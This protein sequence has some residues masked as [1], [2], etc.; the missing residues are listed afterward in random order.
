[1]SKADEHKPT[2]DDLPP[3]VRHAVPTPVPAKVTAAPSAGT[4][5]GGGINFLDVDDGKGDGKP[6]AARAGETVPMPPDAAELLGAPKK[7]GRLRICSKC[8]C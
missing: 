8:R 6:L 1:M 5:N 7:C 4:N 2:A 3:P